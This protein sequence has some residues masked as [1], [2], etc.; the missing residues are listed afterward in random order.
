MGADFGI[1][2]GMRYREESGR[3]GSNHYNRL[4]VAARG[5]GGSLTLA[6][7]A[8]SISF[9]AFAPTSYRGL[10]ELGI[11]SGASMFV[12]L[13]ANLTILPAML[14]LVRAEIPVKPMGHHVFFHVSQLI[15]RWRRGV[16]IAAALAALGAAALMPQVHFDLNPVNLRDPTT[17]SVATFFDLLKDPDTT[18]YTVE[19]LVDGLDDARDLAARLDGLDGADKVLTLESFVP[20][21]QDE[22]LE[23]IAD[24]G[25]TL[26]S[27]VSPEDIGARAGAE[28]NAKAF[29]ELRE[30]LVSA[31]A[32]GGRDPVF[33]AAIERLGGALGAL[34]ESPAWP[35]T[36][37]AELE[38]RIVGDFPLLL[39]RLAELLTAD[40]V[41]LDDLPPDLA[42]RY[43]SA[44]GRARIEVYP[45]DNL[46][47]DGAL[48]R[49]VAAVRTIAPD[50]TGT[51][52]ILVEA[53]DAVIA[54][55]VQ[56]TLLALGATAVLMTVVLRRVTG[57]LLVLLPLLLAIILTAASSVLLRLPLN[58]ANIIAIPLLI[59]LNNAFGIYLVM[60]NKNIGSDVDR[61]FHTS[62]PPAV[63][64]SALTTMASFGSLAVARHPGM[65]Q[66]GILI[67]VA[68]AIALVCALVVLPAVMAEIEH[69]RPSG[70]VPRDEPSAEDLGDPDRPGER[71]GGSAE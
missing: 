57:V 69:H 10:A 21:D 63:M 56:A 34:A 39:R 28:D 30:R 19:V 25:T 11:I 58:L 52:G 5:V 66:M 18:P 29:T 35:D 36:A 12:A 64:F 67:G 3:P 54:A 22:K 47:D 44:D 59:G 68:L 51:P 50:A 41:G 2:F 62:T 53:S 31:Q 1:Q 33:A 65:S 37:L 48:R 13:L 17:E 61:L 7:V 42:A 46:N 23:I 43:V 38:P 60:R 6:A 70:G 8:A 27:L 4:R 32:D 15:E 16:L 49:F 20:A 26:G 55:C 40:Q 71:G 14:T 45:K 24:M 9:F